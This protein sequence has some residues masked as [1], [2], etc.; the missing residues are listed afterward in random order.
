MKD[1]LLN[2]SEKENELVK[3][4]EI[5]LGDNFTNCCNFLSIFKS[6]VKQ[7]DKE[8][9][10]F[11]RFYP[12]MV[13]GLYLATLSVIRRHLVQ[14]N[15][16][17][18][19]SLESFVYVCY[20]LHNSN[21]KEYG[22]I[23]N[24]QFIELNKD[25]KQLAYDWIDENYKS[26]SDFIKEQKREINENFAHANVLIA[27]TNLHKS[28]ENNVSGLFFDSDSDLLLKGMLLAISNLSY[29]LINMLI[30]VNKSYNKIFFSRD[31]SLNISRYREEHKRLVSEITPEYSRIINNFNKSFNFHLFG[32]KSSRGKP[33]E[34]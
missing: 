17:L 24:N 30:E 14:A 9:E 21:M 6:D 32:K 27:E 23:T 12:L 15:M 34:L 19:Q 8:T 31:I 11:Q 7:L 26:I 22:K 25:I 29:H 1:F 13:N 18:R 2:L 16:M 3:N 4:A 28:D 10:V 33:R 20:S 5:D